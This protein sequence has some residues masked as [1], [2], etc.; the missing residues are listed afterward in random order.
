[1][2]KGLIKPEELINYEGAEF[3]DLELATQ[4]YGVGN[5]YLLNGEKEKAL[6]I[7][8]EILEHDTFWSAFGYLATL[9]AIGD[10]RVN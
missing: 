1:M 3:P 6:S 9:V 4:G 5:Y 10:M 2:Y 7:F 8:K